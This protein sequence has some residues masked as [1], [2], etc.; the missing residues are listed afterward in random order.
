MPFNE[1]MKLVDEVNK[2]TST[3]SNVNLSN[4]NFK[5]IPIYSYEELH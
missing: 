2:K 4:A 1:F 3:S 5:V